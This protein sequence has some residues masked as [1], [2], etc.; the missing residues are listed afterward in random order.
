MK[1]KNQ[2]DR[3]TVGS[4]SQELLIKAP[5]T[6]NPIELEREMQRDYLKNIWECIDRSKSNYPDQFFVVVLTK[7]EHL[8]QNV[9]RN[10]FVARQTCPTPNYDQT[11]F[12]YTGK[13]DKLEYIWTI[14]DRETSFTYLTQALMVVPE[15][16]QLLNFILDFKSGALAKLAMHLNGEEIPQ[17]ENDDHAIAC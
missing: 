11:V 9:L 5:D 15:E 16:R 13:D 6:R 4:L 2:P 7:R 3:K 1:R 10:Y 14:P 12:R 17:G 8:M